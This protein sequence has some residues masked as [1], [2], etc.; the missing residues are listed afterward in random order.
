MADGKQNAS[1]PT[2]NK[3]HLNF[4][5]MLKWI[6]F[7]SS[8]IVGRY[9]LRLIYFIICPLGKME[10][11]LRPALPSTAI[12]ILIKIKTVS[13]GNRNLSWLMLNART[14]GSCSISPI[15]LRKIS[16]LKSVFSK[17]AFMEVIRILRSHLFRNCLDKLGKIQLRITTSMTILFYLKK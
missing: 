13:T 8:Q 14:W 12:W 3:L 1:V 6:K 17:L 16:S 2:H 4:M 15:I 11:K 5:A 9:H 10:E 7:K